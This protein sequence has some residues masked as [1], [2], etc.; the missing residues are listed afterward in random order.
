MKGR[1]ATCLIVDDDEWTREYVAELT[2]RLGLEAVIA[3]DG[4]EA[5][6][7]MDER[8]FDVVFLDLDLPGMPGEA[9]LQSLTTSRKRPGAIIVMSGSRERLERIS[10]ARI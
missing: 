3:R 8:R 5:S 1:M 7:M 9:V 2:R 4:I 10:P 6:A